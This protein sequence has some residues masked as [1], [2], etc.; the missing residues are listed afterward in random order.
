MKERELVVVGELNFKLFEGDKLHQ[1]AG[2][3]VNTTEKIAITD[4]DGHCVY[5][6][7]K[8]G[9]CVR[10]IGSQGKNAGQFDHPWGVTHLSDNEILV[11][12]QWNHRI[13]QVN[14]QTGTAVKS[15]GK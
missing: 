1:P 4:Y 12:D 5:I 11:A 8:K 10:Q 3:A 13:Q 7:D 6:F 14:V 2:F 15:F 9:N